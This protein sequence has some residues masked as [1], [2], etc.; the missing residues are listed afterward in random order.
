MKLTNFRKRQMV[1]NVKIALKGKNV[2]ITENLTNITI[3]ENLR[4]V[5]Y[6]LYKT[7]IVKFGRGWTR[8]GW[9]SEG[10]ITTKVNGNFC[11]INSMID[12][13]SSYL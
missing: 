1:F 2:T 5:C 7:A 6:A 3:T 10:W 12:L 11:I 9:T 4:K 13:A 8:E